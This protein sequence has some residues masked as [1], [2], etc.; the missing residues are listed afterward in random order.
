MTIQTVRKNYHF[1]G[2]MVATRQGSEVYFVHADHPSASLRAGL[3]STSLT[4]NISGTVVAETRYLPY[5]EERRMGSGV[6]PTDFTF[7][8][9]RAERGFGLMDYKARYYD[10][11]LNRFISADSIVLNPGNPQDLNRYSYV[12]GNP[13]KFV[14]PSGHQEEPWWQRI[15]G[16]VRDWWLTV[17][18]DACGVS[19]CLG[20]PEV[21]GA[22]DTL[23][24]I[25]EGYQERYL[26]LPGEPMIGPEDLEH[27]Q[28]FVEAFQAVEGGVRSWNEFQHAA[29]GSF[30]GKNRDKAKIGWRVYKEANQSD[31]ILVIGR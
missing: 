24:T 11:Y 30:V 26:G 19:G 25:M 7:T 23:K 18:M 12:R 27:V 15:I 16:N 17:T 2:Q 3:G 29:E 13:V 6:Q 22:T 21:P 5:G 28:Q 14:D 10:P 31:D 1:G 8:G 9:Q 4:T 20:V